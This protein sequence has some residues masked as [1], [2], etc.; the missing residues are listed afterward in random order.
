MSSSLHSPKRSN[1]RLD[2]LMRK[3]GQMFIPLNRDSYTPGPHKTNPGAPKQANQT[4]G[5]GFFTA[6]NRKYTGTLQRGVGSSFED[7]WSQPRLFYNSL[8]PAEKQFL[9]DAMRFENSN[10]KSDIVKNNVI[11]QLNRVDNDLAC[12]VAR[13]IG[14]EEPKPDPTYYH[15]NKTVDVGTFGTKLKKLEGLKVGYLASVDSKASIQDASSLRTSL[16]QDGVDLVVVAERL[17]DGVNQTYSG[18]DAIQF[19][20]VV[21]ANGA[22]RLFSFA[23]LTGGSA[24]GTVPAASTLFPAGRPLEILIDSFRFGKA[25]AAVGKASSALQSAGI[26]SA[27]EGVYVAKSA[28][29]SFVKDI[30]DGLRTFRFLDRFAIDH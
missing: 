28:T 10:V 1:E 21:V 25:V 12:R 18:S 24:N 5:K 7:V 23:S 29:E 8:V 22:E 13:A 20:A 19:D 15:N 30:K 4:V 26:A 16:S 17:M 6:P 9:I 27:R 11:L 14:V 2:V 3:P